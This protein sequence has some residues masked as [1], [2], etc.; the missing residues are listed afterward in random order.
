MLYSLVQEECYIEDDVKYHVETAGLTNLNKEDGDKTKDSMEE[1]RAYCRYLNKS[2]I[3]GSQLVWDETFQIF[4]FVGTHMMQHTSL[5]KWGIATIVTVRVITIWVWP[6]KRHLGGF[7][8][9]LIATV[10]FHSQE[11]YWAENITGS[12]I[13]DNILLS[14][15]DDMLYTV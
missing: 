5:M 10:S 7:R 9:M 3:H 13:S 14:R 6:G 1:C 15:T 4:V 8:A 12:S 11:Y 2:T